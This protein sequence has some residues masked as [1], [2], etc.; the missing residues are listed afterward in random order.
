MSTISIKPPIFEGRTLIEIPRIGFHEKLPQKLLKFHNIFRSQYPHPYP[1]SNEGLIELLQSGK[2]WNK[3]AGAYAFTRGE[4][5]WKLLTK[6]EEEVKRTMTLY[7]SRDALNEV[8]SF[9]SD[10]ENR[11]YLEVSPITPLEFI[12][13]EDLEG[14]VLFNSSRTMGL[15]VRSEELRVD[16]YY[17]PK[18]IK[19]NGDEIIIEN[20]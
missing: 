3:E 20:N 19:L 11:P 16:V 1:Y 6:A 9:I 15:I 7:N 4:S 10:R 14:Y 2:E 8:F 13:I 12:T 17:F 5:G 18:G